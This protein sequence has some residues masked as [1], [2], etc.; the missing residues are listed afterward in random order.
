MIPRAYF[1]GVSKEAIHAAYELS[2]RLMQ[3][4]GLM[5]TENQCSSSGGY[6][7]PYD[8]L[9]GLIASLEND[10]PANQVVLARDHMQ[11]V[12]LES[13]D[14]DRYVRQCVAYFKDGF[15]SFHLDLDVEGTELSARVDTSKFLVKEL[16]AKIPQAIIEVSISGDDRLDYLTAI[17]PFLTDL[18]A[19][20][21][22]IIVLPTGSRVYQGA[23]SGQFSIDAI[24]DPARVVHEAGIAIKEHNAD[25]LSLQSIARRSGLVDTF[26]IA[27]ELG[28]R[29]SSLIMQLAEAAGLGTHA[30]EQEVISNPNSAKWHVAGT[31]PAHM[32][33]EICG[34]YSY[35]GEAFGEICAYL[36]KRCDIRQ[37]TR[38]LLTLGMS[39]YLDQPV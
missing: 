17:R 9:L 3:P 36:E 5:F 7:C 4:V 26:N 19:I 32:I 35:S 21:P 20:G 10:Y 29:Q 16:R 13:S 1:G 23:Q 6:V 37:M 27:P 31:I 34:H 30:F 14:L 2:D 28:F 11:P 18:V 39:R 24:A 12:S 8:A 33:A 15:R 25:F 38:E 22:D